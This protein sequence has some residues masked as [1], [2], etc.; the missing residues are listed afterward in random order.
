M[1][2]QQIT[3]AM[4]EKGNRK[5]QSGWACGEKLLTR[6]DNW[7]S[8][9]QVGTAEPHSLRCNLAGTWQVDLNEIE[10]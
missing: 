5:K 7:R 9:Y 10:D 8:K 1:T 4:L 6:R 3:R 2:A